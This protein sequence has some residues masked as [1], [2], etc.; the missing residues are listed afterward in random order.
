M[1]NNV[2]CMHHIKLL[3]IIILN[4]LNYLKLLHHLAKLDESVDSPDIQLDSL[5][6]LLVKPDGGRAVENNLDLI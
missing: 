2:L 5:S 3:L 6:E 1:D 4:K